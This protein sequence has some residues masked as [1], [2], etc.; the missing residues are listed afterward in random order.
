ML[1]TIGQDHTARARLA[2]ELL[3]KLREQAPVE[4]EILLPVKLIPRNSTGINKYAHHP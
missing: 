4:S 1:T 2:A 3:V